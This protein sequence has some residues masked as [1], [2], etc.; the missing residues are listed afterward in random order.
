[1]SLIIEVDLKT[2]F[3][4][5]CIFYMVFFLVKMR[6]SLSGR[7]PFTIATTSPND[8]FWLSPLGGRIREF[9]LYVG[10]I[11]NLAISSKFGG[12]LREFGEIL[13]K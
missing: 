3:Y 10:R 11:S 13:G 4:S 8:H 1:M 6:Y 2:E 5:T 7:Y 12:I 9:L